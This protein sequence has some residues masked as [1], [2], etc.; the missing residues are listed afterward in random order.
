MLHLPVHAVLLP[1]EPTLVEHVALDPGEAPLGVAEDFI[2]HVRQLPFLFDEDLV[3]VPQVPRAPRACDLPDHVGPHAVKYSGYHTRPQ[4]QR[5]K[6]NL[7]VLGGIG[8]LQ[9]PGVARCANIGF[10]HSVY[11]KGDD[12]QQQ[13]EHRQATHAPQHPES[14]TK[15]C[16]EFL[17]KVTRRGRSP[18]PHAP[19]R[20]RYHEQFAADLRALLLEAHDEVLERQVVAIAED[21]DEDVQRARG[22]DEEGDER[23]HN[24]HVPPM[25]RPLGK[26]VVIQELFACEHHE[27]HIEKFELKRL[28]AAVVNRPHAR[29]EASHHDQQQDDHA[30]DGR[31]GLK[32]RQ[33]PLPDIAEGPELQ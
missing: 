26:G 20:L 2:L 17:E 32:N 29:N 27:Q 13:D 16:E 9:A 28:I 12:E 15:R 22:E 3:A 7:V 6:G 5:Q 33:K 10:P 21:R 23:Q 31:R 11:H 30:H 14:S 8:I 19:E 18:A 1:V 24:Q 25:V 4:G